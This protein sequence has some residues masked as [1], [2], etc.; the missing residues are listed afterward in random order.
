[1]TE[2]GTSLAQIRKAL[3]GEYAFYRILTL[4][5]QPG[6]APQPSGRCRE[7]ADTSELE[8]SPSPE[9][10]MLANYRAPDAFC[11]VAQEGPTI[12]GACWY[13]HGETYRRRNFW[14]LQARE[15]KL[16]QVTTALNYRA[17]GVAE[18]L[19]RFSSAAMFQKGFNRLYA[20][21]WHSHV[22]SLR[23]FEKAGWHEIALVLEIYPLGRKLRLVRRRR[24]A[25]G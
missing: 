8:T 20:R 3:L 10:R 4:A 24:A 9:L 21:I 17:K 6:Q 7:L 25:P 18:D 2:S 16:V 14:P 15:A 1:M 19:I 11:F 22:A 23:A 5:V 12:I 13:W